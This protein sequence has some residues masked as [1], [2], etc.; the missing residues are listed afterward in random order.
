MK[1]GNLT[2]RRLEKVVRILKS[3]SNPEERMPDGLPRFTMNK[4][5]HICGAPAC[6]LGWYLSQ[7]PRFYYAD[8]NLWRKKDKS[9]CSHLSAAKEEFPHLLQGELQT[10]FGAG[11]EV[12][13][14][15]GSISLQN[16]IDFD[17][18]FIASKLAEG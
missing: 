3:I 15:Y 16:V 17:E 13:R 11:E 7:S 4:F 2:I 9:P 1:K 10:L 12:A 18:A 8:G 6:Q 14:Q 5:V